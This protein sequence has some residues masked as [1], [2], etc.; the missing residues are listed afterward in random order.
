MTIKTLI[1]SKIADKISVD[2]NKV[3]FDHS[4]FT[5]ISFLSTEGLK[6][7]EGYGNNKQSIKADNA[8]VGEIYNNLIKETS[9]ILNRY[10]QEKFSNR[11]WEVLIGPWLLSYIKT[12]FFRIKSLQI[13]IE[14]EK[15]NKII[16]SDTSNY[17]F[18]SLETGGIF[19][20][21]LNPEWDFKF[22]SRII[23]N[24]DLKNINF[25]F[26]T[27]E[28]SFNSNYNYFN[29]FKKNRKKSILAKIFKVLN[30]LSFEKKIII[31]ETYLG[32]KNELLLQILNRQI[33]IIL[34]PEKINYPKK[35][36]Q[37]RKELS[38]N[39]FNNDNK[40]EK[41][42]KNFLFDDLPI[43]F[44][45]S[46]KKL[47]KSVSSNNWPSN[48]KIIFTSNSFFLNEQ[49][50]YYVM[51]SLPKT[52]YVV[53]QHGNGY[54]EHITHDYLP[55]Y[56]TCDFFLTWG[57]G[58]RKND[59]TMFNFILSNKKISFNKK[60]N[61]ILIVNGTLGYPVETFEKIQSYKNHYTNKILFL[62]N[63]IK[64]F[65]CNVVYRLHAAYKLRTPNEKKEI[66]KIFS[67]IE[68][69]EGSTNIYKLFNKSKI[70]VFTYYST[71][72]LELISSNLPVVC[73]QENI[74][75]LVKDENKKILQKMIEANIL[76]LNFKDLE[77]FLKKNYNNISDWW[78][79]D[80]I[81]KLRKETSI[82]LSK[83]PDKNSLIKLSNTL[84]N[85]AN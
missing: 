57:K 64:K 80:K 63:L 37:L 77:S 51:S 47:K 72:F 16:I 25:N 48:P 3:Y 43:V 78:M 46:Y 69:N 82:L 59:L 23:K 11:Q 17:N 1:I 10:H 28:Q 70:V 13:C 18:S 44:L 33:P 54:G 53:G 39:F 24:L 22:N 68:V 58:K 75:N 35:N 81:Q 15:I 27:K 36:N 9:I 21:M 56:R 31:D 71:G 8:T 74:L 55:E 42:I 34:S 60:N 67:S 45:E 6:V 83:K 49:F 52:K 20:C 26:I 40:T 50:K 65:Q 41:I 12:L 61:K 19:E 79:S 62:K 5:D 84:N 85:I 29:I 30:L 76:F 66:S 4:C 2:E 38:M 73:L 7:F 14:R 32:L